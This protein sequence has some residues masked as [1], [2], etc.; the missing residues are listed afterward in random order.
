M[1][2][3]IRSRSQSPRR[4]KSPHRVRWGWKPWLTTKVLKLRTAYGRRIPLNINRP[5]HAGNTGERAKR[6]PPRTAVFYRVSWV[7]ETIKIRTLAAKH[8]P[9]HAWKSR[10]ILEFFFARAC[11]V[12]SRHLHVRLFLACICHNTS[13]TFISANKGWTVV[14]IGQTNSRSRSPYLYLS[15]HYIRSY[16]ADAFYVCWC[17]L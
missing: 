6:A 9:I 13:L 15:V 12:L 11:P 17:S 7:G 10:N 5:Q 14:V 2:C 8:P 3:Q 16:G 4:R 1:S